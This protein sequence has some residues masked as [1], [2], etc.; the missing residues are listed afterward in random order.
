LPKKNGLFKSKWAK[1][2]LGAFGAIGAAG[3]VGQFTGLNN[4]LIAPALG[5]LIGGVPVAIAALVV[6]MLT[7]QGG[8]GLSLMGLGMPNQKTTQ[9]GTVYT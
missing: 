5:F 9:I 7:G 4:S 3:L 6:P 1:V 8:G 2:I